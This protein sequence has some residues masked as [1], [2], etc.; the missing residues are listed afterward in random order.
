MGS[1]KHESGGCWNVNRVKGPETRPTSAMHGGEEGGGLITKVFR[2]LG[3]ETT[4]PQLSIMLIPEGWSEVGP[5]DRCLSLGALW[6]PSRLHLLT[7]LRLLWLMKC[8]PKGTSPS[9]V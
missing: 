7:L 6:P 2:F 4:V 8:S 3:L 5:V 9:R 1:W